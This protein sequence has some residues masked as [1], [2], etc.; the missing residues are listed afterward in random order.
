MT[1]QGREVVVFVTA[2][3]KKAAQA[4]ASAL[5]KERLAACATVI[6]VVESIYRWQGKVACSRE[7][8]LIIK[9]TARRYATL[10]QRIKTLHRYDVPEIIALPIVKGS[11]SYL[12]WIKNE[13][14][15]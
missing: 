1:K 11:E 9:T 3:S 14:N 10:E 5:V 12:K 13:T 8:M 2:E 4:I 15:K 7:S 6:G